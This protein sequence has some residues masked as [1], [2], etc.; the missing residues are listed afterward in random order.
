LIPLAAAAPEYRGSQIQEGL[1]S[2]L[3]SQMKEIL[4]LGP[5]QVTFGLVA[6]D[7]FPLQSQATLQLG[8]P[9]EESAPVMMWEVMEDL[10]SQHPYH[11]VK[12][13]TFYECL[14]QYQ[15]LGPLLLLYPVTLE[16]SPLAD[17][18]YS[19]PRALKLEGLE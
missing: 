19:F 13:V 12:L 4:V 6:E 2:L 8:Q 5:A 17:E 15:S 1:A 14:D 7:S 11:A 9:L 18:T 10:S 16:L 3:G